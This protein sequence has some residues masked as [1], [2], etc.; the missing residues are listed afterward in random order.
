MRIL[1]VPRESSNPYQRLLYDEM[2]LLG[3]RTEYL[4]CRTPSHTLNLLLL[5]GEL[6]YRRLT[7]WQ[8][9]HLHWVFSF[10]LPGSARFPALRRLSE[11][12]FA[13]VLWWLRVLRLRL[14]WTA[15]NVLPHGRV[16]ADDLASRRRLVAASDLVITH[17]RAALAELAALG[18]TPRRSAVIPH[19]P[20]IPSSPAETLRVPGTGGKA[21]QI[22]FLGKVQAYKGVENL[23][24]AFLA[25]PAGVQAEL[26]VAG[27]CPDPGIRS[28]L[29]ALAGQNGSGV[30][31]SL[32]RVPDRAIT[33]LLAAADVVAL[34]FERVTTSGSAILALCHGR[35]LIV[36]EGP[37]LADLP[38]DAVVRY[39]GSLTGLVA[40]LAWAAS[41]EPGELA[42]MSGAGLEYSSRYSWADVAATT[43]SELSALGRPSTL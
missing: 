4:G 8:L 31:L 22:L 16:F 5:P 26:T 20:Y 36:P 13:A 17:S 35:P 42:A 24:R 30:R 18:A 9:V 27:E 39:D 7:G 40:A 38:D 21:R 3:A 11:A 28:A 33:S 12:W 43:I 14:V 2:E 32:G 15:H 29:E 25:L 6:A 37:A 34:P 1:A 41:A 10:A 23:V 19:G